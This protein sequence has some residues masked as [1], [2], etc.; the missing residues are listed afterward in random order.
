MSYAILDPYDQSLGTIPM[1]SI[2]THCQQGLCV[3]LISVL[4][5]NMVWLQGGFYSPMIQHHRTN[6][7]MCSI[8]IHVCNTL[9]LVLLLNSASCFATVVIWG[10]L[11]V[12]RAWAPRTLSSVPT[13]FWVPWKSAVAV[14]CGVWSQSCLVSYSEMSRSYSL[15]KLGWKAGA[16]IP[17]ES[18]WT[19]FLWVSGP[20]LQYV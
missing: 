7:A 11:H 19:H 20:T 17:D 18:R 1:H 8:Y 15:R 6:I 9:K 3:L 2:H 5:Y 10:R 16:K 4:G 12:L 14:C 13:A